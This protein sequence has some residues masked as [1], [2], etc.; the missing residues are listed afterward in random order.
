M[1]TDTTD[2]ILIVYLNSNDEG[3]IREDGGHIAYVA[4][5]ENIASAIQAMAAL[6]WNAEGSATMVI[7][8][9]DVEIEEAYDPH[10]LDHL[11]Y[12]YCRRLWD[13]E[14]QDPIYALTLDFEGCFMSRP[15]DQ[16]VAILRGQFEAGLE[17][18]LTVL[19]PDASIEEITNEDA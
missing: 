6:V 4:D 11:A 13:E 1:D 14:T 3:D 5:V 2:A 9:K 17:A 12:L 7:V 19:F 18:F 16:T 10:N 15:E 8:A